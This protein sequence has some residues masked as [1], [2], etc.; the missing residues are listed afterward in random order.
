MN[1]LLVFET[2]DKTTNNMERRVNAAALE[3]TPP[4]LPKRATEDQ[5]SGE[6]LSRYSALVEASPATARP[7]RHGKFMTKEQLR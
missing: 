4:K 5:H 6:Q 3:N 2:L 1:G 7:T